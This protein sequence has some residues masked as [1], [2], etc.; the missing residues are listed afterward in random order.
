MAFRS[1]DLTDLITAAPAGSAQP[2]SYRQGVIVTFDPVTLENTVRVG[3]AV[4]TNLNV[5]GVAEAASL[6]VGSVV[7][8]MV[9]GSTWAIIGRMVE[10]ASAEATDAI[11]QVSQRIYTASV[12]TA[13]TTTA[14]GFTD[15]GTLGPSVTA[16]IGASG[17]ALVLVTSA[18]QC[19]DNDSTIR[20]AQMSYEVSGMTSIIPT[21]ASHGAYL[22]SKIDGA[23]TT[24]EAG[25]RFT[26][27]SLVE[28]LNPGVN[29]FTAKYQ[30]G[31]GVSVGFSDRNIT[32]FA[33]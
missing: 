22:Q 12:A 24:G 23:S 3:G 17:R 10:P 4:L 25:A 5:L 18:F 14:I 7:G 13:E 26:A 6:S 15:L 33:L 2:M 9:V 32:V 16:R 28:S 31:N 11:T 30:S 20:S 21:D 1:D 29:I 19:T 27:A 8:L